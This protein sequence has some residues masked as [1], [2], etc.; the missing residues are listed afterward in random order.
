MRKVVFYAS[1][2]LKCCKDMEYS[3]NLQK[4]IAEKTPDCYIG[5]K[6][7]ISERLQ[8]DYFDVTYE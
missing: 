4:G 3:N 5:L 6:A 1:R 2:L 7:N 8:N